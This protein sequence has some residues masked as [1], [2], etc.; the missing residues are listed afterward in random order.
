MEIV[1]KFF[2]CDQSLGIGIKYDD[3]KR[4][5]DRMLV[6]NRMT[7]EFFDDLSKKINKLIN[8]IN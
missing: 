6:P 2:D 5:A 3:G 8:E 4:N 1:I 7:E